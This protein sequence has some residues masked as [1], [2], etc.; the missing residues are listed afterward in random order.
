MEDKKIRKAMER[1]TQIEKIL[2]NDENGLRY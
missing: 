1:R 2:E